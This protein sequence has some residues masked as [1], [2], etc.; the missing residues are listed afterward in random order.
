MRKGSAMPKVSITISGV[1]VEIEDSEQTIYELQALA[2]VTLEGAYA[3]EK[4][5]QEAMKREGHPAVGFITEKDTTRPVKPDGMVTMSPE[6]R[7]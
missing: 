6:I 2:M 7:A 5:T 4:L 3:L 1:N